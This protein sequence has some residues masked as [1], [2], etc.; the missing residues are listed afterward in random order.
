MLEI[1]HDMA[2][3]AASCSHRRA[4]T[5]VTSLRTR[6][7]SRTRRRD[8]GGSRLRHRAGVP[9]RVAGRERRRHRGGGNADALVGGEHGAASCSPR[10]RRG[11]GRRPRQQRAVRTRAARLRRTTPLRS[12]PARDTTFDVTLGAASGSGASIVLQWSEPRSIF[13]TAGQ[14]GFTDVDLYVMDAGADACLGQAVGLQGFGSGDTLEVVSLPASLSGTAAKIV[15]DVASSNGAVATPIIDLRGGVRPQST[16]PPGRAASTPTRTTSARPRPRRRSTRRT[17][18]RSSRTRR[19][20]RSARDDHAMRGRSAVLT[21]RRGRTDVTAAGPTW[22]AADN[23]Y[24]SGVGGFGSPFTGTSA[25]APHAAGCDA[26]VRDEL[27]GN[28]AAPTATARTLLA[29]TALDLAPAGTDNV[30][31]AGQLDCL[32]A[33]NDPPVADPGGPYTRTKVSTSSSTAPVRPIPTSATR[34]RRTSGTSTTT[35]EYDD[36]TGRATFTSVGQDGVFASASGSRTPRAPPTPTPRRSRSRTSPRRS[37]HR[38]RTAA[39]RRVR[40][41]QI[42]GP[43]GIRAGSMS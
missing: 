34:S 21:H 19:R 31:G 32:A 43:P 29:T 26:L 15:V 35:A 41:S 20:S 18:P 27:N 12:P 1:V 6:T 33:I 25:A 24:V 7:S 17:R 10:S 36:A 39:A 11:H 16:T 22:A 2:P 5:P 23:V 40:R 30:T 28:A 37:G 42:T 3:G 38:R 8:H 14:G 4:A 13:P 9:V